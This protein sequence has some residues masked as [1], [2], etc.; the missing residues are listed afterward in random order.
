[1][2]RRASAFSRSV[3]V[4][5]LAALSEKVEVEGSCYSEP[6]PLVAL[7]MSRNV[8]PFQNRLRLREVVTENLSL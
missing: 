4:A 5:E 2:K 7:S 6:Q 1:M 8:L 3:V